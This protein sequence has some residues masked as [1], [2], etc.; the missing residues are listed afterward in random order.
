MAAAHAQ[1]CP[2][3]RLDPPGGWNTSDPAWAQTRP[4]PYDP[5]AARRESR[6]ARRA[7][8]RWM[9]GSYGCDVLILGLYA[10]AGVIPPAAV[11][12][13]ALACLPLLVAF[14]WAAN[15]R[16]AHGTLRWTIDRSTRAFGIA[17]HAA[18]AYLYPALAFYFVFTLVSVLGFSH[19]R[20]AL[21]GVETAAEWVCAA[22]LL[23]PLA[24]TLGPEHAPALGSSAERALLV[25]AIV[26]ITGRAALFG[27]WSSELRRHLAA[28]KERYRTLCTNLEEQVAR[29]TW[30]LERRNEEVLAARNQL[31]SL[32]ASVAHDLRQPLVSMSGH[33]ALARTAVEASAAPDAAARLERVAAGVRQVERIAD[34]LARLLRV[35]QQPLRRELVDVSALVRRIQADLHASEPARALEFWVMEGMRA[36]ADPTLL[37]AIL[38]KLLGNAWRFTQGCPGARI[39]VV[40]VLSERLA[41]FHVLDNGPGV[42]DLSHADLFEPFALLHSQP[43]RVRSGVGLPV[44]AACA[45]RHGG[46]LRAAEAPQ[47]G[48]HFVLTLPLV[49]DVPAPTPHELSMADTWAG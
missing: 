34:G 2:A 8:D 23:V 18:F 37:E 29:R 5:A 44:A 46:W 25:L 35:Y 26:A 1:A 11:L 16:P 7:L 9:A 49:G 32:A 42:G 45:R 47:G 12:Q 19:R 39:E 21:V 31:E 14:L 43:D 36:E 33:L 17:A 41:E 28:A 22:L 48:A 38:R 4:E 3:P 30:H 15:L 27:Y 40:Q 10:A 24:W 6:R 20:V 13:Y